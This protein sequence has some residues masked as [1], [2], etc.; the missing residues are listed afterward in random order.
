MRVER[1]DQ[2]GR[3]GRSHARHRRRARR[4]R[5][6]AEHRRRRRPVARDLPQGAVRSRGRAHPGVGHRRGDRAR[7]R[8]RLRTR[9]RAVHVRLDSALR[10]ATE[11]DCGS[12]QINSSPLWRADP[13]PYG[14]LKGE[15]DRQGGPAVRDRGDD[16]AEDRRVPPAMSAAR[17]LDSDRARRLACGMTRC[18]HVCVYRTRPPGGSR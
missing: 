3:R 5:R 8:Q 13:M 15:R 16:G 12:I 9:G 11:V 4:C 2:G 17:R 18:E 10:F 14:G 7:Q 6:L 1:D